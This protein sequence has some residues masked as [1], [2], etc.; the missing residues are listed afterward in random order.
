[1]TATTKPVFFIIGGPG[2]GK[3]TV[4]DGMVRDFGFTHLSAGDM[5]RVVAKQ[6][7]PLGQKIAGILALGQIV[8]SEV[9]VAM[10][11]EAIVA[12]PDAAGFIIDG[13]PRKLDQAQMFEDGITEAKGIVYL[14]CEEATMEKRLLD[15][16]A[17]GSGR[18]DDN[19]ETI[20]RRFRTNQVECMP[21][22]D[23][24]RACDRLTTINANLCK[25]EVYAQFSDIFVEKFGVTKL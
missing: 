15:R 13:F 7:T 23:K 9:T 3:G 2:S 19:I 18:S 20:R 22:V 5:L 8:P 1:M 12:A 10:L 25:E 24:Y 11:R 14:D 17:Q 16:A 6:D 21:V 4:C